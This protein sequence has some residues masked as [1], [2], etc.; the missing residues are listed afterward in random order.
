MK[1]SKMLANAWIYIGEAEQNPDG[2]N[3]FSKSNCYQRLISQNVY[4]SVDMLFICLV[5][6]VAVADAKSFTIE[7]KKDPHPP[8]YTS[9][10][11]MDYVIRDARKNNPGIRLMVTLEFG[12]EGVPTTGNIIERVFSIPG[13]S[14]QQNAHAFAANLLRYL[15]K[16]KLDGFDID[17]EEPLSDVTTKEHFRYL[18]NAIGSLFKQQTTKK[19][20]L[21][22]SPAVADNMDHAAINQNVDFLNLQLYSGF[23]S[24]SDFG[25]INKQLF[26]YGA[27][28]EAMKSVTN[29][30]ARGLQTAQEAYRDN[31]ANYH[32]RIFT[33]WR[34]NS[35][36][37]EFEQD[38]QKALHK[39][40]QT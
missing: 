27:K 6:T 15:Q 16:Y 5:T 10:Q 1:Q 11:Y 4:Q 9:Q 38:Q 28:F 20:Y 12:D 3:Y 40:A 8:G 19:Y 26:A 21:T 29:P 33:N 32:Y 22:I 14:P 35:E 7:I 39:L 30:A 34:L 36:N 17:W 31:S 37:F 24:P 18:I 13:R 23:T 25:G 2:T